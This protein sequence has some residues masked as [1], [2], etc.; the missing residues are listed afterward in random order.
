MQ[1]E[2]L[3]RPPGFDP[4]KATECKNVLCSEGN[5]RLPP[6]QRMCT[7]MSIW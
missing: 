1:N 4:E 6:E 2:R 3:T 5:K 7:R